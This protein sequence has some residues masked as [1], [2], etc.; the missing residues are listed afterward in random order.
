VLNHNL[1]SV[2]EQDVTIGVMITV[3]CSQLL[4]FKYLFV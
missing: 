2:S 4:Q 1:V 3:I